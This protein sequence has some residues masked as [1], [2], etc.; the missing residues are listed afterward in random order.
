MNSAAGGDTGNVDLSVIASAPNIYVRI[1]A[2]ATDSYVCCF[3]LLFKAS[4]N[5][6]NSYLCATF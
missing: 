5:S 4:E 6:I 3:L 2:Q 1:Q